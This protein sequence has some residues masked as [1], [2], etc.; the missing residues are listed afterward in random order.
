MASHSK[1]EVVVK[2]LLA[3]RAQVSAA[4]ARGQTPLHLCAA[5]GLEK[6]ALQLIEHGAAIDA[7]DDAGNTPIHLAVQQRRTKLVLLLAQH[8]ATISR[9][10]L[11]LTPRDYARDVEAHDVLK[12][13]ELKQGFELRYD[14]VLHFSR[15]DAGAL[16]LGPPSPLE[17]AP[18]ALA[19]ERA[20][21]A[22][23]AAAGRHLHSVGDAQPA[24][25]AT[26]ASA[27]RWGAR[28]ACSPA[29]R[30][31]S[32]TRLRAQLRQ[33]QA[34]EPAGGVRRAAQAGPRPRM[35]VRRRQSSR[36]CDASGIASSSCSI[37]RTPPRRRPHGA[38]AAAPAYA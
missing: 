26:A 24:R 32:P 3:V 2:Q 38:A 7:A 27:P 6:A 35:A 17:M 10:A 18:A 4:D 33:R 16:A 22:A 37:Q 8:A 11:G 14:L 15:D 31:N 34:D 29:R 36:A 1:A 23:A 5:H 12:V 19:A 20:E 25:A 13:Q 28:S 9:N 21:A 30:R